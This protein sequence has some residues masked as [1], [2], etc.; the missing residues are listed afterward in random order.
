MNTLIKIAKEQ[1]QDDSQQRG[2]S[3]QQQAANQGSTSGAKDQASSA[4]SA[5]TIKII[6]L[7]ARSNGQ[8][9]DKTVQI[10]QDISAQFDET[11]AKRG[12]LPQIH[13]IYVQEQDWCRLVVRQATNQYNK[14]NCINHHK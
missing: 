2:S 3:S 14:S 1:Q 10:V 5:K 13:L 12:E 9:K 11:T 4:Q 6:Y 7:S 8:Y